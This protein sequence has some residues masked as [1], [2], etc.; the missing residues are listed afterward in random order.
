[1]KLAFAASAFALLAISCT[2]MSGPPPLA[3]ADYAK[4]L[5][6]PDRAVKLEALQGPDQ[7]DDAARKPAEVLAYMNIRPGETILCVEIPEGRWGS[8]EDFTRGKQGEALLA[9][10]AGE[11]IVPPGVGGCD[12]SSPSIA[13]IC[14]SPTISP[15][16]AS[17]PVPIWTATPLPR[18][19]PVL[20]RSS[21]PAPANTALPA[22][23][24]RRSAKNRAEGFS[25]SA[26]P[27][28]VISNTPISSVAPK[29]FFTARNIR[30]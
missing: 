29:R 1:M 4:I 15:A 18:S 27:A 16:L 8:N 28:P 12:I 7:A 21:D 20:V 17:R 26:R 3:A 14:T 22:T 10:L 11:G 19:N 25:T 5:A 9:Q 6:A 23:L 2:T 30:N 24:P 13:P